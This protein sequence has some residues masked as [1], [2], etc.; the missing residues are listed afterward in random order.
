M[1]FFH[2]TQ[3]GGFIQQAVAIRPPFVSERV[4]EL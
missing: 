1:K 3:T 4:R 2:N